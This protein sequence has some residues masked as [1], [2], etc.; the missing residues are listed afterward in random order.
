MHKFKEFV[1]NSFE[2]LPVGPE[3]SWILSHNI[4][5]VGGNDCLVVFAF[6]LLTQTKEVFD[7]RDQKSLLVFFV[8]CTRNTA[9][10]PAK[11]ELNHG[12]LKLKN[13][14]WFINIQC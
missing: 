2:E 3:K 11:L 4:H 8:H 13:N 7:N 14:V 1:D 10:G 6:L 5:N 9:Y 12:K